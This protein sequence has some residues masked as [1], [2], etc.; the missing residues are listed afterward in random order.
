MKLHAPAQR[1]LDEAAD[2]P[3]HRRRTCARHA[4]EGGEGGGGGEGEGE[5][6][7]EGGGSE[8]G[9]DPVDPLRITGG[10]CPFNAVGA[11]PASS[12]PRLPPPRR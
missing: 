5:G 11:A 9:V 10:G 12:W 2:A 4:G 8:T 7:G 6:E 3:L 1:T